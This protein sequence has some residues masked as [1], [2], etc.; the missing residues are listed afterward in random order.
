MFE[1]IQLIPGGNSFFS[2]KLAV[3]ISHLI[4]FK[5]VAMEFPLVSFENTRQAGV[6]YF[7]V[8]DNLQ[9]GFC[10]G[11]SQNVVTIGI[12]PVEN[13]VRQAYE[14]VRDHFGDLTQNFQAGTHDDAL[15]PEGPSENG[16][17]PVLNKPVPA[18]DQRQKKGLESLFEKDYILL[19]KNDDLL[20]DRLTARI[21][22]NQSSTRE[23][24]AAACHIAAR[25]G[26]ETTEIRYPLTC[27]EEDAQNIADLFVFEESAGCSMILDERA[28]SRRFVCRGANQEL[29]DFTAAICQNFPLQK[30]GVRWIDLLQ[31]LTL[32]LCMQT[33]DG[34]LTCLEKNKDRIT[35]DT[36][37][38]FSP[39][40]GEISEEVKQSYA[41]AQ[42]H[43]FK[44]LKKVHEKEYD[45]P[46]EVDVCKEILTQK[47]WPQVKPG[48]KLEI[49]AVLSEDE[50]IRASLA[51][52]F[53][54][55]AAERGAVLEKTQ[56]ICAHKQGLS[57][58]MENVLPKLQALQMRQDTP[59]PDPE[60]PI[61]K[62]E[63]AFKPFLAPGVTE[64]H[65]EDGALPTY[66]NLNTDDENKWF[67]LS[68][69]Y[70]QELYPVDDILASGLNICRDRIIFSTYD[71][72]EDITYRLTAQKDGAVLYEDTYKASVGERNYID[73]FPGMG[74]VHPSTGWIRVMQNGM[75]VVSERILT[76]VENVWNIYQE[77]ILP[78]CHEYSQKKT[79][80]HPTYDQ[81][82]FFAQ[83]RLDLL[84]SEPNEKL[85][86][87]EDLYSTLD[88]LH[89]DIYFVGLDYF[90]V[91]G[92]S[93]IGTIFDAPGLILPIINKRAGKPY[94]KFTLYDQHEHQAFI[95]FDGRRF[96]PPFV[97]EMI[98]LTISELL[99]RSGKLCPVIRAEGPSGL[100]ATLQSFAKLLNEHKLSFEQ[101]LANISEVVFEVKEG[102]DGAI[103][104]FG[105][106]VCE[107]ADPP[108]DLRIE[109]IE[110]PED[111]VIGY[112]RYL[113]LIE[114]LKRV[115]GLSVYKVAE[116]YLG[117]DVYAVEFLTDYRGYVSRVKMINQ[118]PVLYINARHHANEPSG[119]N[120]AFMLM[121]ELLTKPEFKEMPQRMNLIII[122]FENADGAAIHHQLQQDN[123]TW[124]LHIARFNA[125]GKEFYNEYF[126]DETMHIEA[127]GATRV[128]RS[129]LPDIIVDNHGVPTHEWEQQFSGYTSPSYK[130]FWLP[131]SFLYGC[132]WTVTDKE[133]AGNLPVAKKMEDIIG[134][135]M[136]ADQEIA[137][138]NLEWQERFNKYAHQWLPRLFPADYYN[139][140][141]NVW[142]PFEHDITHRYIS[143]RYPWITT[144]AY[145][146]ET[147]DETAQ[148]AYLHLAARTHVLHDIEIIRMLLSSRCVFDKTTTETTEGVSQTH[149]RQRPLI[150]Q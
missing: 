132:F 64:W 93:T 130:G 145:T 40:V 95:D 119:S 79:G 99:W 52:E 50:T 65:D 108:K 80:N 53:R 31:E 43:N 104:R 135:V 75:E 21:L 63:I 41:P 138:W 2:S 66:H 83:M 18:F 47:L 87:R 11:S 78:Y 82:P 3:E 88:S 39:K 92:N 140:M 48:D 17:L 120:A 34:Q 60:P 98:S 13:A 42:F 102:A 33:V 36:H 35:A 128:W 121:R 76:D 30:P 118:N 37:C 25:L 67:D 125:L 55:I 20:A 89:E 70:L 148:G 22:I 96:D 126:N 114:Q 9:D 44:D 7:L 136:A 122:P 81:Q 105:A 111:T 86:C 133:W 72:E 146:S 61:D 28:G 113:E 54:S 49:R 74:K 38:Y 139:N 71:G 117:R 32:G 101:R 77:D 27:S 45:I 68:I 12:A 109:H 19:D 46:W 14:Y 51:E 106:D 90:K 4:G 91:Y 84:L 143:V 16:F 149:V 110:I 124:K 59:A 57:W 129:W 97:K 94:F 127:L 137:G 142:A 73:A 107:T 115:P 56:I 5:S 26:L 134:E 112:E 29:V 100:A 85:Q 131:R 15:H 10:V 116:T 69:R 62:I 8:E 58:I 141:I 147:T 144:V 150:A 123:P 1:R 103:W 23:Q 6:L 24:T